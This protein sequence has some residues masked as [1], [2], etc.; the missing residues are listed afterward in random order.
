MPTTIAPRT[1]TT[2]KRSSQAFMPLAPIGAAPLVIP[3][4]PLIGGM[5]APLMAAMSTSLVVQEML[6]V[7]V[8][9]MALL[10]PPSPAS[11]LEEA[12]WSWKLCQAELHRWM[13]WSSFHRCRP[14][15]PRLQVMRWQLV[16]LGRHHCLWMSPSPRSNLC[17]SISLPP[18]LGSTLSALPASKEGHNDLPSFNIEGSEGQEME[19]EEW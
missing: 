11:G 1:A 10:E 7:D 9:D 5:I 8:P 14:W 4:A 6:G 15:P 18:P 16:Y 19:A 3:T 13:W 12:R 2:W 17:R